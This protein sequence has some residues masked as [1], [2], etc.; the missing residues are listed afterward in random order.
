MLGCARLVAYASTQSMGTVPPALYSES[1]LPTRGVLVSLFMGIK[2]PLR[3]SVVGAERP[4][5]V[6]GGPPQVIVSLS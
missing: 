5:G 3:N 4:G 2:R 6:V 1:T